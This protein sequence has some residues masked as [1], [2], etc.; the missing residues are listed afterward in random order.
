MRIGAR[1]CPATRHVPPVHRRLPYAVRAAPQGNGLDVFDQMA[2]LQASALAAAVAAG[3]ILGIERGWTQRE[4]PDGA[5]VAG[6]RTFGLFGLVGGLA[7]LLPVPAM[8]VLLATAGLVV[9]VGYRAALRED[10]LSATNAVAALLTLAIGCAATRLSPVLALGSA[11]ASFALLRSRQSL[12]ALLRGLEEREIEAVA[13]FLLV[14]LVILPILPDADFGPYGAWNPRRIWM[15]VVMVTGLSFAGYVAAR[16]LGSERGTMIVAVTGALVSSTAVTASFA[17]RLVAEPEA[18]GALVAGIAMASVVMFVRVQL[19]TLVLA[20]RALPTLALVLAPAVVV[21]VLLA[22]VAWRRQGEATGGE[23]AIGN[24]FDFGPALLLAAMV[25]VLSLIARWALDAFGGHGMALLLGLTGM[26][27][28]DAAVMTL[29]GLPREA[30]ADELAGLVLA[31]PVLANTLVKAGMALAL[32]GRRHG[33]Q[34][35]APLLAACAASALGLAW[36]WL[37]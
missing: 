21:S 9:A 1:T 18:R 20:P 26:M 19:V 24:P 23:V 11:A 17:R 33:M 32:G 37:A 2:G 27:D 25:A 35:A 30:L 12:H 22:L 6:I 28:V 31:G 16:R 15:V 7:G 8:T 4:R 14:S 29:S 36:W 13:R 5:R 10:Q 34:A 3:L